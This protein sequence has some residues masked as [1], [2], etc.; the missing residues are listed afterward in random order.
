MG[1][2]SKREDQKTLTHEKKEL[3]QLSKNLCGV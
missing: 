2:V 1:E 3:Q